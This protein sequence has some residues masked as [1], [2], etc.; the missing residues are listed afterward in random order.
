[1]RDTIKSKIIH[2]KKVFFASFSLE[3]KVFPAHFSKLR[4]QAPPPLLASAAYACIEG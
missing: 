4:A 2:N 1:M 3:K